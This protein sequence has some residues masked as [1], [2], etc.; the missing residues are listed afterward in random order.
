[1]E[2]F[3]IIKIIIASQY[4]IIVN[5]YFINIIKLIA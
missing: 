5:L 4:A 3:I 1:M 2:I